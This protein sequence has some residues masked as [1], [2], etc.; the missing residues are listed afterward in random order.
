MV[1]IVVPTYNE[2]DSIKNLLVKIKESFKSS[3]KNYEIVCIDDHSTDGTWEILQKEKANFPLAVFKKEGQ[4][5]KAFSLVEGFQKAKGEFLV[6][7]DADLQYPPEAIPGMVD[8]LKDT[9]VVVANRKN[10]HHSPARKFLSRS[11][12]YMF[13][14]FLF[15]L[16]TD[17]QSGLKAFRRQVFETVE[18][19]PKSQWTFDLEFLRRAERAGF[20][21]ANYDITFNPRKNGHSKLD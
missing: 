3:P 7:I 16:D 1:S 14:K 8:A 5:G 12:R 18:F 20:K 15:G 10:Y 11:F 17:I 19:K 4:K 13:G 2:K 21:I 9:D 6:M